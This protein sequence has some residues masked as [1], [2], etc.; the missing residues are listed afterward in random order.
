[1]WCSRDRNLRNRDL[2][3]TSRPRL[4]QKSWD[5]RLQNLC[6]LPIFFQIS[7][8]FPTG[9]GCFLAANTTNKSCWVIEILL[10]HFFEIFKVSR[11]AAFEIE[12]RLETFETEIRKMGLE[13]ETKSRDSITDD[14]I[15]HTCILVSQQSYPVSNYFP[16]K[17]KNKFCIDRVESWTKLIFETFLLLG[18]FN[19]FWLYFCYHFYLSVRKLTVTLSIGFII[20]LMISA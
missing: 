16:M 19:V 4:H 1:M 15:I 17:Y 8:I 20:S 13:T 3:K 18:Y 12:T 7:S 10:W 2:V 14:L 6:I 11:P 9:F 5:W